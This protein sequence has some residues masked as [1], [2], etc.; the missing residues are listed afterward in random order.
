M[1]TKYYEPASQ[2]LKQRIENIREEYHPE[3]AGVTISPL[4]VFT[5]ESE[6][7]LTHA[8]YGAAAVIRIVPVKDRA[9]GMDDV[10]LVV[11]RYVYS[12]LNGAQKDALVDH[13]LYHL[14]RAV[15]AKTEEPK[16]DV[17]GR[18]KLKLR[19]HDWQLGGF[20]EIARRHGK[21][22][23]EISMA[24]SMVTGQLDLFLDLGRRREERRGD[25]PPA[26]TSGP[27]S[28]EKRAAA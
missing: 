22:A 26:P 24:R 25:P 11:D 8:G 21:S 23:L 12:G 5:D 3:L 18:P 1:G 4:F 19:R 2:D 14:E 9:S 16:V 7:C 27:G 13:E 17:L 10:Q 28:G 20:D 15:D 6:P